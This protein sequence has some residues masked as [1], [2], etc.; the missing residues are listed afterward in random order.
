M[1]NFSVQDPTITDLL[2]LAEFKERQA[3]SALGRGDRAVY[4]S[5]VYQKEELHALAHAIVQS[6]A[7]N[8]TGIEL[9]KFQKENAL[10]LNSDILKKQS[11]QLKLNLETFKDIKSIPEK[12]VSDSAKESKEDSDKILDDIPKK[13]E[14]FNTDA[15]DIQAQ[16]LSRRN[17][18]KENFLV[19]SL[20]TTLC[21]LISEGQRKEAVKLADKYIVNWSNYFGT[22][23]NKLDNNKKNKIANNFVSAVKD[24]FGVNEPP[25][26]PRI[27][28][29][30]SIP[31]ETWIYAE[32]VTRGDNETYTEK[33]FLVRRSG[34]INMLSPIGELACHTVD[35]KKWRLATKLES[36][37]LDKSMPPF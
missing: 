33:G 34:S 29:E 28:K 10:T 17:K 6:A 30:K 13:F 9:S 11:R 5:L 15:Q 27:Q 36:E 4:A 18:K 20:R 16:I 25:K 2:N 24:Q 3:Q 23:E 22:E 7:V 21:R 37:K 19:S 32:Y 26:N 31:T 8:S 14:N 35:V 12:V 1:S